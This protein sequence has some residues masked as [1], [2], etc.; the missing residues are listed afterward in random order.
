[1][2]SPFYLFRKYQRAF[3]AIAAVV[4]MFIF[5]LADPL[6]SW[7]QSSSG[8]GRRTAETVV[9]TWDGGS[10]N[11][12]ELEMLARRRFK[13][14]EFLR[15]LVGMAAGI[16]EQ[17]GGSPVP[18]S[19]P[20]FRLQNESSRDVQVGC[21]T[22]RVLAKQAEKSGIHISDQVINHYLKEWGLRR[23]G[24]AEMANLLARLGISD[25]ALFSG[26]RELLMGNFYINSYALAMQ[27]VTPEERWQDWKRINQRIAVEAAL[28]PTEKFLA[29]LP[30]PSEAQL[31]AFY[32]EHK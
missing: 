13:V 4:A 17:E 6:M 19:L 10:L 9:A 2:A 5:V 29:D 27:G 8:G 16:I 24:D 12:R 3:I 21:V 31:K 26:I 23:M 25:K 20:D 14:S 30:E 18:P 28:L 1:M 22:T 15:N 11:V 7:I 32:E